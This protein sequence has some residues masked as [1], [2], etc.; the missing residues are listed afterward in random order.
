LTER[1]SQHDEWWNSVRLRV[2][3]V[4]E[5]LKFYCRSCS[6]FSETSELGTHAA[7]AEIERNEAAADGSALSK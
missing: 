6:I 2:K 5:V 1:G 7:K 4:E 3:V